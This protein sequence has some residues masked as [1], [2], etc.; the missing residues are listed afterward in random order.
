MPVEVAI[1]T[2]TQTPLDYFVDPIRAVLRRG[3]KER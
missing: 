1:E 3:M 2:G